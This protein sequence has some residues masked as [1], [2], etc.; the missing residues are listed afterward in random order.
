MTIT[1]VSG[2]ARG[3]RRGHP[4]WNTGGAK[5]ENGRVITAKNG[6]D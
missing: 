1:I 5:M 6:G 4:R 2:I 3:E